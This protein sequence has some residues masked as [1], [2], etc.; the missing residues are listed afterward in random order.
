VVV[1]AAI[2]DIA[3]HF[4]DLYL[5]AQIL[6]PQSHL[7]ANEAGAEDDYLAAAGFERR[8]RVLQ[9]A[10]D[11]HVYPQ[12][13]GAKRVMQKNARCVLISSFIRLSSAPPVPELHLSQNHCLY[14]QKGRIQNAA[15]LSSC[16]RASLI[17]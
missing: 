13:H 5:V 16:R 10:L 1:I 12:P 3:E 8:E 14:L 17:G 6:Q 15:D 9:A 4:N 11:G 2:G 7:Y